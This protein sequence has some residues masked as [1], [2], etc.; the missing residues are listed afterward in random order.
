[1][2]WYIYGFKTDGGVGARERGCHNLQYGDYEQGSVA[3]DL[4]KLQTKGL[5]L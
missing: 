5:Q 3:A 4:T 1:M 2:T